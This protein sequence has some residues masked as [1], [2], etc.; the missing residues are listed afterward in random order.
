MWEWW[1]GDCGIQRGKRGFRSGA[2]FV[3]PGPAFFGR[4]PFSN[5]SVNRRRSGPYRRAVIFPYPTISTVYT[6]LQPVSPNRMPTF[7]QGE[8][9]YY[10]ARSKKRYYPNV[11]LSSQGVRYP[12]RRANTRSDDYSVADDLSLDLAVHHVVRASAGALSG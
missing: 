4:P 9:L 8:G 11:P 7:E 2:V 6:L 10:Y 12:R 1:A 3:D 5:A